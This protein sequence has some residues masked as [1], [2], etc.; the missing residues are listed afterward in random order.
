MAQQGELQRLLDL[1]DE[2]RAIRRRIQDPGLE[3]A[4]LSRLRRRSKEKLR[5]LAAEVSGYEFKGSLH[6]LLKNLEPR[7]FLLLAT[8]LRRFLRASTPY[9]EGRALL[10]AVFDS[11]FELL[12]GLELLQPDGLLRA[13]GLVLVERDEEDGEGELLESRF[14]LSDEIVD[15]FLEEMG[16][17][18][19][20]SAPR[21][22]PYQS[23]Q[24]YLVDLKLL[25]NLYR[26]RAKRLFSP[27]SW[28][29]LRGDAGDRAQRAVERHIR[30]VALRI[31]KRLA[32]TPSAD[33]FPIRK[34][35]EEFGLTNDEFV[36]V[37]HL[38][39]LELLEGNPY[40]DI[41]ALL[42]L[43]SRSEE[44]LIANRAVVS[45]GQKLRM[46]DIIE[47]EQMI[48][49]RELTSECHLANW[50]IDRC[51]GTAGSRGPIDADERLNFHLYLK[52]LGSSSFLGDV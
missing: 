22:K 17:K 16:L 3:T 7:H 43:V 48:E 39:F 11:S 35:V 14:R 15:A 19:R 36:M 25:H 51:F 29:R 5:R 50:V 18:R 42:Q 26:A 46:R 41:V 47:L 10:A 27:E 30:R 37:L 45:S 9:V 31:E 49:G 13:H 12:Q 40:A 52:R 20:R 1:C 21:V 33:E 4:T 2:I 32:R 23:Q 38:L 6:A 24:E 28:W 8:L 44:E 34:F